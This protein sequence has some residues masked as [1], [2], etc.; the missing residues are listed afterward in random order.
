MWMIENYQAIKHLILHYEEYKIELGL[1]FGLYKF[2]LAI[3]T[4]ANIIVIVFIGAII[5]CKIKKL[6][7]YILEKRRNK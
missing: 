6:I 2:S 5:G 1:F 7:D 3:T 4:I